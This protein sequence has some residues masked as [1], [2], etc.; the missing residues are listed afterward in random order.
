MCGIFVVINKK[1]NPLN[2]NKCKEG[3][4]QLKN[5]G[6]NWQFYKMLA[7]NIFM[8]QTVLSM[9]GKI[10]KDINQHYS[11]NKKKFIVFPRNSNEAGHDQKKS[12]KSLEK[13]MNITACYTQ[14]NLENKILKFIIKKDIK[15]IKLPKSNIPNIIKKFI[16]I[17]S[18]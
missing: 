16:N 18:L 8:S 2:V 14:K 6:P 17:N 13:K 4:E 3:L 7:P 11:D 1:L 5:R 9:T 15:I 12:I 10:K